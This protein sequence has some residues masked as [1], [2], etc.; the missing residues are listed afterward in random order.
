MKILG[1]FKKFSSEISVP[2]DKSITHRLFIFALSTKKESIIRNP[3]LGA[4]TLSTLAIVEQLGGMVKKQEKAIIIK[5][6]GL[7]DLDEPT[8][9]L[10]CGN[11]GTTIRLFSGLLASER[12]GLFIL[13]GDNSLRNRPMGRI[14][15]PLSIMGANIFSRRNFLA[16]LAIVGN[17]NGLD[18]INYEMPISS[19]QLKSCLIL[20]GLKANSDTIIIEPFPSRDHTE[21][22]L[23]YLGVNIKK[24][25]NSIYVYP[26]EDLNPFDLTVPGDPSSAAFFVVLAVLIPGSK[27][28]VR[29]VC[30]NP[31]RIGYIEVLKRMGANIKL[32]YCS[33]NPEPIGNIFVEGVEKLTATNISPEEVPKIIDEVPIISIAM[34]LAEGKSEVSGALDLRKKES[35][36]INAVCFNLRNMGVKVVEKEDGFLIEG[37]NE[38]KPSNIKTFDDHRIAMAFTI[39]SLLANGESSI[40]NPS[41]CAISFPDFYDKLKEL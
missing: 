23:T 13:T 8:D 33:F 15:K 17:K 22:I 34:A 36:R 10:N 21:L 7:R 41:C 31:L 37:T 6:K 28:L 18:G 35:D 25:K 11:S 32:E 12:K 19:A 30:L 4:D 27:L 3:L 29:D 5:G 38:L 1:K 40:D 9:I 2:S 26:S 24:I 20:A 39:A 16:P 14:I